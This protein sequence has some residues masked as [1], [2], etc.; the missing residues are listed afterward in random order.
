MR[1][2]NIDYSKADKQWINKLNQQIKLNMWDTC[3]SN[4]VK[5][6]P[7]LSC[8]EILQCIRTRRF[9]LITASTLRFTKKL[10][11][12]LLKTLILLTERLKIFTKTINIFRTK[13]ISYQKW[14]VFILFKIE[15][16]FFWGG[17]GIYQTEVSSWLG[18]LLQKI[19]FRGYKFDLVVSNVFFALLITFPFFIPK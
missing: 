15:M 13:I 12:L 7:F 10:Q 1:S 8:T 11:N 5:K 4:L 9:K 17:G 18:M 3:D 2:Q 14:N 16:F 19:F 6:H